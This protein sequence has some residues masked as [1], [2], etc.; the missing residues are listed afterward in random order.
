M[1]N[2]LFFKYCNSFYGSQ[3]LL[4]YNN[5]INELNRAWRVAVRRVW[6]VPWRTRCNL[7]PHLAGAMAP[8]FSFDKR[9]IAFIKL[10]CESKNKTVHMISGMGRF[11]KHSILGANARHLTAKYN[12]SYKTLENEW[13]KLCSEQIELI[14]VSEQ[15]KELCYMRDTHNTGILSMN[16]TKCIIDMLCTA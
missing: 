6:R 16:D 9:A 8:E 3:F 11:G 14:R 1:Q 7:L 5:T 12:L 13:R 15:I 2:Y 10:C 4:I